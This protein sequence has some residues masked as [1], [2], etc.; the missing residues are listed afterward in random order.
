MC[1]IAAIVPRTATTEYRPASSL[2]MREGALAKLTTTGSAR[3]RL[4]DRLRDA[5]AGAPLRGDSI[6]ARAASGLTTRLA[7]AG[8][9]YKPDWAAG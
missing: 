2:R 6:F 7:E 5:R 3:L 8:M 1:P 4:G 9:S